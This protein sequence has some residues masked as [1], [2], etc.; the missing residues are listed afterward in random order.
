MKDIHTV[1][2]V[3]WSVLGTKN[4]RETNWDAWGARYK[5][6]SYEGVWVLQTVF[7]G[8]NSPDIPLR[9]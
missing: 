8:W 4:L 3:T 6:F 2:W 9:T 7:D 1:D 5:L